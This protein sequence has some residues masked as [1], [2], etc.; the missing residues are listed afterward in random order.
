MKIIVDNNELCVSLEGMNNLKEVFDYAKSAVTS[1]EKL[2]YKIEVDGKEKAPHELAAI[3]PDNVKTMNLCTKPKAQLLQDALKEII[4]N[5]PNLA[6]DLKD[7][8]T[9]L[10][11]GDEKNALEEYIRILPLISTV[12]TGLRAVELNSGEDYD[13]D[14][15]ALINC[16]KDINEAYQNR[17]Y[18]LLADSLEYVFLPWLKDMADRIMLKVK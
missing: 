1:S 14:Y 11:K 8:V 9:L 2:I 7:V 17:D 15:A 4:A 13:L 6:R 10:R 18:T 5:L 3:S 12:T 16:L